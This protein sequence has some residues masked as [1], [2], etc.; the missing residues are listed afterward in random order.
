MFKAA[1]GSGDIYE[2]THIRKDGSRFPAAVY[3]PPLRD[4]Q[5][6]TVGPDDRHRRQ[7]A[8]AV[9]RQN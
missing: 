1:H 9:R 8:Q 4:S 7:G 6:G 2:L 3:V 5:H